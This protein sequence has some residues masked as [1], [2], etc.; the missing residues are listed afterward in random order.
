LRNKVLFELTPVL[1]DRPLGQ[2]RTLRRQKS[3]YRFLHGQGCVARV[4]Q[5]LAPLLTSNCKRVANLLPFGPRCVISLT[6]G[7]KRHLVRLCRRRRRNEPQSRPTQDCVCAVS[8]C[9]GSP[10]VSADAYNK[11]GAARI[12]S[13]V[14]RPAEANAFVSMSVKP[15][16]TSNSDTPSDREISRLKT[17]RDLS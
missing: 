10:T 11:S 9:P 13:R 2:P 14:P 1:G 3:V 7:L 6:R 17:P 12:R 8:I 5:P 16:L 4:L 15:C